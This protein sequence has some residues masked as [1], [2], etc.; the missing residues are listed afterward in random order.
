MNYDVDAEG[1]AYLIEV[2]ESVTDTYIIV[3]FI[4]EEKVTTV[5]RF[6]RGLAE[7]TR[8]VFAQ[9]EGETDTDR[10]VVVD[11]EISP[12]G[13]GVQDDAD[14]SLFYV[15]SI[16]EQWQQSYTTDLNANF[17]DSVASNFNSLTRLGQQVN[18]TSNV[19]QQWLFTDSPGTSVTATERI[20]QS[21]DPVITVYQRFA[22]GKNISDGDVVES[23]PIIEERDG[24]V[25]YTPIGSDE[26]ITNTITGRMTADTSQLGLSVL[27]ILVIFGYLGVDYYRKRKIV[28][29]YKADKTGSLSKEEREKAKRY[30]QGRTGV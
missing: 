23:T 22:L 4:D 6:Q 5:D 27:M 29:L 25:I 12:V 24:D 18:A 7:L 11:R 14:E 13:I 19:T 17:S 28:K 26:S 30:L 1:D 10:Q 8:D 20:D 9:P 16:G 21:L 2:N 15:D 3:E